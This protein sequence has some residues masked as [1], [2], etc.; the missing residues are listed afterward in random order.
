MKVKVFLLALVIALTASAQ[1][2]IA[3]LNPAPVSFPDVPANFYAAEAIDL[4]V[5]SGIIVG[6]T[7]GRFDGNAALD[8]Y[9]AAIIIARMLTLFGN[10]IQTIYTDL[11]ALRDAVTQ[12][13]GQVGNND[14]VDLQSVLTLLDGKAN[15]SD[16]ERVERTVSTLA[17]E[18]A[19][20]RAQL[21]S[22]VAQTGPAGP[23]G[24]AGPAGPPGPAGPAGPPGA[25][26]ATGS[27][28]P[29]G[30]AGAI[31]PTG[32]TGASAPVIPVPL[33]PNVDLSNINTP[34]FPF[35]PHGPQT[36]LFPEDELSGSS[37]TINTGDGSQVILL[38]P[39][40]GDG[41]VT[42][43]GALDPA[44]SLP[45][46][47]IFITPS[48]PSN[49]TGV[50]FGQPLQP[51]TSTNLGNGTVTVLDP[52]TGL[53]VPLGNAPSVANALNGFLNTIDLSQIGALG[54]LP[55]GFGG[56]VVIVNPNLIIG[57]VDEIGQVIVQ[58]A[59]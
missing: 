19:N 26:G 39:L 45:G 23:P 31:G 17:N 27:M 58:S 30:P 50:G 42:D 1:A 16:I 4:A 46:T 20:L 41:V 34:V 3:A 32:P 37:V 5:R 14:G 21:A 44:P 35:A 13:Q 6:R 33:E 56:Q 47:S 12:L 28:G 52:V 40:E 38:Q 22:N 11:N 10:D 36:P 48:N 51:G 55:A 9:E 59:P 29:A 49:T 15:T 18:V 43:M 53:S 24:P 57:P 7:D 25:T 2:Q 8:R 54:A